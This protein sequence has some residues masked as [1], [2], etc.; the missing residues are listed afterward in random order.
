MK[1]QKTIE[2]LASRIRFCLFR[3]TNQISYLE[4]KEMMQS[5]PNTILLDVRSKQEYDEY[6]L[7]GAICVPT[8]EIERIIPKMIENKT[9]III[10]YCQTG[11]RSKKAS[12]LLKKMGYTDVYEMDG[13]IDN[14]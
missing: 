13:G 4:A 3:D 14:M 1:I 7:D 12:I 8:Y 10:C 11:S 5:H 9:Q 6:H 2:K